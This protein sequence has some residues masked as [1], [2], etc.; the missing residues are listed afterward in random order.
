VAN[1]DIFKDNQALTLTLTLSDGSEITDIFA[2]PD[3]KSYYVM[4]RPGYD[5]FLKVNSDTVDK[6]RKIARN[7]LVTDKGMAKVQEHPATGVA[8]A[9]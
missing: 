7:T 9:H 8:A 3:K 1:S 4:K 2:K 6:I 5:F